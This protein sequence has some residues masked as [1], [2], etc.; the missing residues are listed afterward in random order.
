MD[1][2]AALFPFSIFLFPILLGHLLGHFLRYLT[3][4]DVGHLLG[5][6]CSELSN[7]YAYELANQYWVALE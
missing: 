4:V 5:H 3:G 7:L 6:F 2:G 1:S